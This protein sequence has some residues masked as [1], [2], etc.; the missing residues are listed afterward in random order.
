[1]VFFLTRKEQSNTT[2]IDDAYVAVLYVVVLCLCFI[3]IILG[4][5]SPMFAKIVGT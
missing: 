1:M 5:L 4:P 2:V 3:A